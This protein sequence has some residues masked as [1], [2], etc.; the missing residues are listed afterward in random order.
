MTKKSSFLRQLNL[1]GF[2]RISVGADGGSYYHEKFLRGLKF[3]CRRMARQKVNG[4]GIRAAGNPDEE[5]TLSRF[6]ACP[7]SAHGVTSCNSSVTQNDEHSQQDLVVDSASHPQ[8]HSLYVRSTEKESMMVTDENS[9][10]SHGSANDAGA[11]P[12]LKQSRSQG[13]S[14]A[15]SSAQVSFPL[16]LHRLLDKM[17]AEGNTEVI[18]W[19]PHGRAFL[20][21]DVERFVLDIMTQ[22]FNQ[23]KY[24][25]F[26]RQLHMYNFQRITFG[27][28]KGAYHHP[29]FQRGRPNLC[30][31]MVRTRVNGKGCRRPGDPDGEPCFYEQEYLPPIPKG[32][33]IEMPTEVST[34]AGNEE[35]AETKSSGVVEEEVGQR[36][37]V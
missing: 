5:P 26:Q 29:S 7:P 23:T 15:V 37:E 3:L 24:S 18:S 9:H 25:S 13:S 35:D 16:K 21:H 11:K 2:N 28:D 1:Y 17:E 14:T 33:I 31:S 19:L 6:P 10:A 27:R 36:S 8:T 30:L 32:T 4:N 20:V 12:Q 34:W 22:Y